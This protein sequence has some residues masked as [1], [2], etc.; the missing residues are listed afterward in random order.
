MVT[1]FYF[2]QVCSNSYSRQNQILSSMKLGFFV[3]ISNEIDW[4]SGGVLPDDFAFVF[5]QAGSSFFKCHAA[6]HLDE[7]IGDILPVS[8]WA[9]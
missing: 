5:H 9:F 1:A 2:S 6:V 4:K 7:E 3:A 8:G